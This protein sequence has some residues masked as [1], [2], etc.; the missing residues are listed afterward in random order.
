MTDTETTEVSYTENRAYALAEVIAG[1]VTVMTI[2][3]R[4]EM[5]W[6]SGKGEMQREYEKHIRRSLAELE[7]LQLIQVEDPLRVKDP[8]SEDET[9]LSPLAPRKVTPTGDGREVMSRWLAASPR[10]EFEDQPFALGDPTTGDW[11]I[12]L[13]LENGGS[14]L[15]T[16]VSNGVYTIWLPDGD[17]DKGR[18]LAAIL[19]KTMEK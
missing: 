1:N 17:D 18:T 19:N 11:G 16:V 13:E 5:I 6:L 10:A 12:E 9:M 3:P 14:Q 4:A 8:W 7:R 15:V 2:P